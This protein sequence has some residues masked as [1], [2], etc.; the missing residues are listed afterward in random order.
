MTNQE[1]KDGLLATTQ[2]F[3]EQGQLDGQ[4]RVYDQEQ[5]TQVIHYRS[6][7][8]DGS[9][10]KYDKGKLTVLANYINNQLNGLYYAFD[11][12]GLPIICSTYLNGKKQGVEVAF[13]KGQAIAWT[14]YEDDQETG[15]KVDLTGE[16]AS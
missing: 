13:Q 5:L 10:H 16:H 15:S 2:S 14:T 1:L 8:L 3:N 11:A 6:G 4:T 7:L 12:Q 9:Y